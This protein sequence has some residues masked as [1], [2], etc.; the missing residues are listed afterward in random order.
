MERAAQGFPAS[1]GGD[2]AGSVVGEYVTDFRLSCRPSH[3][4]LTGGGT[5]F[6]ER[7]GQLQAK[8]RCFLSALFQVTVQ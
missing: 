8:V 2:V 6:Q 3:W 5:S 4:F 1:T 7:E